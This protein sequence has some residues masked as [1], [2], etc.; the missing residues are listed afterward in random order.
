MQ[1]NTLRAWWWLA[2]V[3]MIAWMFERP[4]TLADVHGPDDAVE[5]V[6]DA[7]RDTTLDDALARLASDARE[8]DDDAVQRLSRL[9]RA[10]GRELGARGFAVTLVWTAVLVARAPG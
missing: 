2:L 5:L 4:Q 8:L 3:G 6:C 1:K 10:H 7:L 9:H